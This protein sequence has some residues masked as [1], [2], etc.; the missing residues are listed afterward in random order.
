MTER[1][2]NYIVIK[3]SEEENMEDY[4]QYTFLIL[5]SLIGIALNGFIGLSVIPRLRWFVLVKLSDKVNTFESK[6]SFWDKFVILFLFPVNS[7]S[8]LLD[9][10]ELAK[11]KNFC[12]N[13]YLDANTYDDFKNMHNILGKA[14]AYIFAFPT[15]LFLLLVVSPICWLFVYIIISLDWTIKLIG[16]FLSSF[17]FKFTFRFDQS[18]L[19]KQNLQKEKEK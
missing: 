17:G 8:I 18:I 16:N 1:S 13:K 6:L 14:V 3:I 2:I 9:C 12:L 10:E 11:I 15:Y 7:Y 5:T 4:Y 19:S